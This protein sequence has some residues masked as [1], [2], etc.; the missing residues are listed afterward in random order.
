[1]VLVPFSIAALRALKSPHRNEAPGAPTD[2]FSGLFNVARN[3]V[4]K[5]PHPAA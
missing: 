5:S 1:L 2:L 4:N 3:P